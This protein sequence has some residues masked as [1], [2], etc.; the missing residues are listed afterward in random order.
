MN[1]LAAGQVLTET[2]PIAT[3][4]EE[5]PTP[6]AAPQSEAAPIRRGPGRPPGSGKK[7]VVEQPPQGAAAPIQ[8]QP[9]KR[10]PGRPVGSGAKSTSQ[11]KDIDKKALANQ[12]L[13][14]HAAA[15]KL[16]RID[17]LA[18][19]SDEAEM[20]ADS[21]ATMM[22][23]YE[24]SLSGKTA[25]LFGMIGT[26]AIIYGPRIVLIGEQIKMRKAMQGKKD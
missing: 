21:I 13:F 24:I 10:G 5:M 15:A 17:D 25:A 7:K 4:P 18:I 26:V 8:I 1:T 23:E 12:L 3:N 16:T 22:R 19:D 9:E 20:L 2:G 6:V 11:K 14:F